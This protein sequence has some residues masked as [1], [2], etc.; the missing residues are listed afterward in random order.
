MNVAVT[1]AS[2]FLGRN[3]LPVLSADPSIES[4]IALDMAPAGPDLPKVDH[5]RVD[6]ASL[7]ADAFAKDRVDAVLH[8]AFHLRTDRRGRL[9]QD[10]LAGTR[11][12]LEAC[13]SAS[14]PN[15]IFLSSHTIY[16]AHAHNPVPITEDTPAD[17][18]PGF[19]YA[20][21]K[22]ACEE[23]MLEYAETHPDATVAIL[24]SCMV[25]GPG[26][27]GRYPA[28][29][30]FKPVLL[31]LMGYDP[32]LQFVHVEDLTRLLHR[33]VTQPVAGAFNVA[34]DGAIPY[35]RAA[36]IASSRLLPLPVGLAYPLV[37]L[38]WR[39]GLQGDSPAIGLEYIR[40]PILLDTAKLTHATG[41]RFS[42]SS[43]SAL[44]AAF[45]SSSSPLP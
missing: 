40:H 22:A 24:R 30:L 4:I 32:L 11:A 42:H 18:L 29:T 39:L 34:G 13:H 17:P 7:P 43:E 9:S 38:T 12:L 44:R 36:R 21:D 15:I 5:R 20:E 45:P 19:G 28:R 3:L 26:S 23:L 31:R 41:F 27:A 1:G 2:G 37:G 16:G 8:L 10:N 33:L 35:S 14:V 25:L 6:L